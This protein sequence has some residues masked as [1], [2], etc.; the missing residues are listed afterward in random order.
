MEYELIRPQVVRHESGAI[1]QFAGRY[2]LHYLAPDESV[3][4]IEVSDGTP[5]AVYEESIRMVSSSGGEETLSSSERA[6][7]LRIVRGALRLMGVAFE[8][9]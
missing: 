6:E 5:T 3:V 7:V 1:V 9:V 4:D 8:I 2:T